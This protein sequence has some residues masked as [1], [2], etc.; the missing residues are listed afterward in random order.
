M[1][2][3]HGPW[4]VLSTRHPH[5][6]AFIEV[7]VDRVVQPDGE[8]GQYATV[9]MKPGVTILPID[10]DGRVHLVRQFRYALG[11]ESLEAPAGGIDE[12]EEPLDA[13]KRELKEEMG[14]EA[15]AWEPLGTVQIDTSIV[16][17]PDHLFV[18]RGL[19]LGK[20]A[21]EGTE[22]MKTQKA[23]L[24]EAAEMV[25][26]GEIVQASSCVLILLAARARADLDA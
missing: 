4:T 17:C 10:D 7:A 16:H 24:A 11:A 20:P 22:D 23:T 18:A 13:A 9:R 19:T 15:D 14:I 12:G 2:H 25:A 3:P 5:R 1:P 21:R 6:D 26:R 8:P